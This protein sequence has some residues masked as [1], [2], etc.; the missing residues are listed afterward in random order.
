MKKT[1]LEVIFGNNAMDKLGEK[2]I[3]VL[4]KANGIGYW[5]Y[6]FNEEEKVLANLMVEYGLLSLDKFDHFR[7]TEKGEMIY[8]KLNKK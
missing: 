5:I 2:C 3:R 1:I 4:E 6:R 7:K 8:N